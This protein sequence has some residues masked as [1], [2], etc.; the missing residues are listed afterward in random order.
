MYLGQKLT[1]IILRVFIGQIALELVV[2][3]HLKL[4]SNDER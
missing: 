1:K 3:I 4:S 2:R